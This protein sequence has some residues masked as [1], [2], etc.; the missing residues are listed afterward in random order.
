MPPSKTIGRVPGWMKKAAERMC[1][2]GGSLKQAA[3]ELGVEISIDES[4]VIGRS[5]EFQ[6]ILE[7]EQISYRNHFTETPGRSKATAI[8]MM[9]LAIENLAK[10]G[11]WDKVVVATEKLAKLEGWIGLDANVN[12]F[13]GLTTKELDEHK[14]RVME[15]LERERGLGTAKD[16][17]PN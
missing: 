11:E 13:A 15:Q 6:E 14:K 7:R 2:S 3:V 9:L 8:G 5:K 10:E 17:L 12:I 4:D 16:I 1:W